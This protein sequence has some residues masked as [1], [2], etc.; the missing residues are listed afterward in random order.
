MASFNT[1]TVLS[2][3]TIQR[4]HEGSLEVLGLSGVRIPHARMRELFQDAGAK[5]DQNKEL[6]RIPKAMVERCLDVCHKRFVLAGR[7]P[8]R[9]A[10]FGCGK[11]NYN[12]IFGEAMWLDYRT[13]QRRFPSMQDVATAARV[14]DALPYINIAGAMADPC[15]IP[16]EYRCVAV[17][18]ELARNTTKPFGFWF[19]D[20]AS[21]GYVMEVLEAVAGSRQRLRE[22]PPAFP[23]LEPISPLAFTY[24]GIDVL[25]ETCRVPLPVPIGP[26]A[27]V[28]GTAPGT[29]A[30]TLVQEN[31][32]I[33]AG[34]CV[35]QL[36]REGTPVCYGG[37]PHALDMKTTQ[38]IFC[39]PEQAL[40]AVG[41]VQMARHYG[42]P[43]YINVGLTDSKTVDAQAGLEVGITLLS[44]ALAG[45]DIFGHMGISGVDQATSLPILLMQHEIIA[46]IERMLAGMDVSDDT[47]A[48]D[49]I[50]STGP[51][52][53]YLAHDHT[54]A[55]FR[56]EL[57]FPTLLDRDFFESWEKQG[58]PTMQDRIVVS[59]EALLQEHKPA[60]LEAG[61]DAELHRITDAARR[62]LAEA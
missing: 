46:Y 51:G 5:V 61:L 7:D 18:S 6:V 62:E 29:L 60:P 32:E 47:L 44:G 8:D 25:F 19:H 43:V 42:L 39:G 23:F 50:A 12:S 59:L 10:Q 2:Q 17:A 26:M 35:T 21:A 37:I 13:D 36:I 33:L 20:R 11:R 38:M 9:Q 56:N 22:A 54:L 45:A 58:R 40:M 28:G 15:E 31:A 34:I 53:N 49:V 48:V 16:Q 30:G 4:I 41:M 27:Q 24:H 1:L 57:W 52:G 3:D 55:H 14:A